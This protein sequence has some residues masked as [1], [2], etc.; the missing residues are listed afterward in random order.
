MLAALDR[1]AP[2]ASDTAWRETDGAE[3]SLPRPVVHLVWADGCALEHAIDEAEHVNSQD[4]SYPMPQH[5]WLADPRDP[6][7]CTRAWRRWVHA[8]RQC[9]AAARLI[10]ALEALSGPPTSST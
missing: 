3:W 2:T 9:A 5:M 7:E 6:D 10:G 4:G 1:R 8:L